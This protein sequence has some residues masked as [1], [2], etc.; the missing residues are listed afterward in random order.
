MDVHICLLDPRDTQAEQVC[1]QIEAQ[2]R[3]LGRSVFI[4]DREERPGVKFKDADLLGFPLRLVIGKKAL[5]AGAVEFVE[6]KTKK[7]E[8]LPLESVGDFL[9][10]RF[11]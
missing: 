7:A 5:A 1:A 8:T 11:S 3:A 2:I 9:R 6:R 4:D 10:R